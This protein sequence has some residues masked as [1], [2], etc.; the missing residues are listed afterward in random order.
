MKYADGQGER[1]GLLSFVW[2]YGDSKEQYLSSCAEEKVRTRGNPRHGSGKDTS[3]SNQSKSLH[4]TLNY[5]RVLE[6]SNQR[7]L[8]MV[9]A[10]YTL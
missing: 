8:L 6:N 4:Y 1:W 7:L 2:G 10:L 3:D 5:V 9:S